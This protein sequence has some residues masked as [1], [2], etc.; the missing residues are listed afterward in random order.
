M[1]NIYIQ[2]PPTTGKVSINYF[3]YIYIYIYIINMIKSKGR[4][5]SYNFFQIKSCI[6]VNV[7]I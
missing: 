1:S 5:N 6:K 4:D 2:E 3:I 7:K